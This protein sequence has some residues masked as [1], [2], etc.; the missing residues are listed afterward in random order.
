M[1]KHSVTNRRHHAFH[2][3]LTLLLN[4]VLNPA[5]GVFVFR[6]MQQLCVLFALNSPGASWRAPCPEDFHA[7][8]PCSLSLCSE[9]PIYSE[10]SLLSRA[11]S[12][13]QAQASSEVRVS[14][15]LG[16][17]PPSVTWGQ[18]RIMTDFGFGYLIPR[19]ESWHVLVP[20]SGLVLSPGFSESGQ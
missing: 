4:L 1:I 5:L 19:L 14:S 3:A 12:P 16:L 17:A 11:E 18:R 15:D 7:L 8:R 13:A 9:D 6:H 20:L 10:T 2:Q